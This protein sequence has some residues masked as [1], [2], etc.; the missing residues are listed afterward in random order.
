MWLSGSDEITLDC[1]VRMAAPW[2]LRT[3][4]AASSMAAGVVRLAEQLRDL[5]DSLKIERN[6]TSD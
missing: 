4:P 1:E 6:Y 5:V 3:M 2:T